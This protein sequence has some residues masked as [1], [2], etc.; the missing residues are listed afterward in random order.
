[1]CPYPYYTVMREVTAP[2]H[3]RLRMVLYAR[4]HGVKPAA[5][6]F[7]ATPKTVRKW[8]R[9]FDGTVASLESRS[10]RPHRQPRKLSAAAERKIVE[11]KKKV[12]SWAARRLK[13]QFELPYSVKAIRRVCRDHGLNRKY[14][15]RKHQTKRLLR[16]VKKQWALFQQ[17]DIDTKDLCDI[18]EYWGQMQDRALP[19]YQYTFREVTSGLLF[20]GFS[21][22]LSLAYSE[23]FA[24]RSSAICKP[25]ESTFRGQ[26]GRATT[27]ASSWAPGRPKMTQPSPNSSNPYQAKSTAPSRLVPTASKPTS[28]RFITSWKA[29]SM[30]SNTSTTAK[31]SW[32]RLPATKPSSTSPVK[33]QPRK[34]KHHGNSSA[35]RTP[36][37]I[38][39][40][41][42]SNPSSWTKST[43]NIL[44][45]LTQGGTMS[46]HFPSF[47]RF[48]CAIKP[49]SGLGAN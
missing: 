11:L 31:P 49:L 29:S 18:P 26:H 34:T 19:R 28:K 44:T 2:K 36:K 10:R 20:L 41:L 27:A 25:A 45:T 6:A 24:Q 21:N 23:L 7:G 5:Q 30:R 39:A 4:N 22:E 12:R 15:R 48:V 35:K 46:G 1:M 33:T 16:E 47:V 42:C 32:T 8:L 3:L 38:P 14:R 43:T 40:C 17:S 9:R 13:D 37:P